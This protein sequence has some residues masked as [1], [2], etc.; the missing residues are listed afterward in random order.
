MPHA[1]GVTKAR[2]GHPGVK[3][4]IK[5]YPTQYIFVF[6]I[7]IKSLGYSSNHP[8]YLSSS[9]RTT[10]E[11]FYLLT[12]FPIISTA[13]IRQERPL[14]QMYPAHNTAILPAPDKNIGNKQ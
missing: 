12:M 9:M 13:K 1:G 7:L 3:E 5:R 14:G 4:F 8:I 11:K 2:I 10:Y 6:Q